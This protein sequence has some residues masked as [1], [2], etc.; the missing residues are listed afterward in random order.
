MI[1]RACR[2]ATLA[3]VVTED[4]PA[5]GAAP[6]EPAAP[7]P[8]SACRGTGQ[9]VSNLGGHPSIVECPWCDGG[10]V[11]IADHDAQARRRE[12]SSGAEGAGPTDDRGP[13][14]DQAA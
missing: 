7:V 5:D 13:D 3:A 12:Q 14:D 4:E 10:G 1:A 2:G 9:V 11:R 8:C 6:D